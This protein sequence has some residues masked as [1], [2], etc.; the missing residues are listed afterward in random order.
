MYKSRVTGG[1]NIWEVRFKLL[2]NTREVSGDR[3]WF[4]VVGH[5]DCKE[6]KSVWG[7][8]KWEFMHFDKV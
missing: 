5:V 7:G 2:A 1:A 6:A 4:Y 3:G 8:F